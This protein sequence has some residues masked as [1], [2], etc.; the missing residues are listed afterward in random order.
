MNAPATHEQGGKETESTMYELEGSDW[1]TPFED[2]TA[3][4]DARPK[5]VPDMPVHHFKTPT[6]RFLLMIRCDWSEVANPEDREQ[7][8]LGILT[9]SIET[10]GGYL[11]HHWSTPLEYDLILVMG[12]RANQI[13]ISTFRMALSSISL[14]KSVRITPLKSLDHPASRVADSWWN[15]TQ[16]TAP[17]AGQRKPNDHVIAQEAPTTAREPRPST[18]E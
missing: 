8:A 15:G 9:R 3:T 1:I 7:F 6:M 5:G 10:L 14:I 4:P 11:E 2:P 16:R 17:A 18:E 12:L 13:N